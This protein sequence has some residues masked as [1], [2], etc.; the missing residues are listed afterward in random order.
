MGLTRF[1]VHPEDWKGRKTVVGG[2]KT[3]NVPR[4]AGLA[5]DLVIANKEENPRDEVE[6]VAE[7]APVYVTDVADVA[8]AVAMIRA[9]GRLVNRADVAGR[10][11][12][13]VAAGFA[14][15]A[16][17]PP[18][19]ALALIWRD[20]WMTVGGDTFVSDVMAHAGLDN[21]AADRER[22]PALSADEIGALAPDVVLLTS[23]PYP[24][25]ERHL[26][27]TRALAPGARVVLVDGEAF[28]WYGS[29]LCQTPAVLRTLS[30]T[31][32]SESGAT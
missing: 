30:A 20:P 19:R 1:C 5:P 3:I 12:D 17:G 18:L 32:R 6:A 2:T 23:E 26:A 25:G 24:F 15:L 29:R 27:E 31:L 28:S 10:L 14:S 11:A 4:L 7:H 22:Y 21:V 8:G 9:V 16:P 13:E